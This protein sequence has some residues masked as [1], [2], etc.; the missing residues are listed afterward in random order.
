MQ[1]FKTRF[2]VYRGETVPAEYVKEIQTAQHITGEWIEGKYYAR[3]PFGKDPCGPMIGGES[4]GPPKST[5]TC[6]PR[7][8]TVASSRCR[9]S[10]CRSGVGIRTAS[11]AASVRSRSRRRVDAGHNPTTA[12]HDCAVLPGEL[13]V[14]GCDWEVCPR[15][16]TQLI[17]CECDVE[18]WE[19]DLEDQGG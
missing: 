9:T 5:T 18:A 1:H 13:H 14:Q 15:F 3:I 2:V 4:W 10:P 19:D 7:L 11:T 17:S 8:R 6:S 16:G 12:C